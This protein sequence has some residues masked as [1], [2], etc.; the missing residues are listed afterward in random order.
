M[1]NL[2][3][4]PKGKQLNWQSRRSA[5]A[6]QS[7]AVSRLWSATTLAFTVGI[8]FSSL[9]AA[10]PQGGYLDWVVY[11][12]LPRSEQDRVSAQ[13]P[14]SFIDPWT[15]T[16]LADDDLRVSAGRQ[17]GYLDGELRVQDQVVIT[18]AVLRLYG[19]AATFDTESGL[20][21][22]PEGGLIRQ[23][24]MA[25]LT[26][27]A[28]AETETDRFQ[29]YDARY[30]LHMANL[31]GRADTIARDDFIYHFDRAWISRCTPGGF[32][33][34]LHARTLQVNT[35]TD[36]AT[37]YHGRLHIGPVP[38]AYTPYFRLNLNQ[39]RSSGFLAPYWTYHTDYQQ[40]RVSTP[41]YWAI[42]PNLDTTITPDWML[43]GMTKAPE[44][45]ADLDNPANEPPQTVHIWQE[46]RYLH[47]D[48]RG[49]LVVGTYPGWDDPNI[50]RASWAMDLS[51]GSRDT[52]WSWT[53]DYRDT[54]SDVY[55]SEFMGEEYAPVVTN[56]VTAGYQVQATQTRFD[57]RIEQQNIFQEA[58]LVG[59]LV[60]VE[61]P[62]FHLR[63]PINLPFNWRLQGLADWE[64]RYKEQ[65]EY[66][67]L[68]PTDYD[69]LEAYRLRNRSILSRADTF[70]RWTF[71]QQYTGDH[72]YYTMPTVEEHPREGY[73]R[74]LWDTRHRLSYRINLPQAQ[75]VTP[76]VQHEYRP[77]DE[78]QTKLPILNEAVDRL[79]DRNR[80]SV[81]SRYE[82]ADEDWRLTSDVAQ[83]VNL[84]KEL[85][86]NKEILEDDWTNPQA[87]P[88]SWNTRIISGDR[89]SVGALFVWRAERPT[90]EPDLS[91]YGDH[92]E[93][94]RSRLDYALTVGRGGINLSSDWNLEHATDNGNPFQ[95]LQFAAVAP[96]TQVFGVFG[97]ATLEKLNEDDELILEE[98]VVG[99][100]Y[101]GCCW[102]VQLAGQRV[103]NTLP[104][105]ADTLDES[106]DRPLFDTIQLNFS[107]KGLVDNVGGRNT[108][109][110]S[111]RERIPAFA[112]Q[113]FNTQ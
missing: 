85:L 97:S 33:W 58:A 75:T 9:G 56:R 28:A 65:P 69:P 2:S 43:G 54:N 16:G 59:D 5:R 6:Q 30:T 11:D 47:Q 94:R 4:K 14:G 105:E 53:L 40:Y 70:G 7:V 12:D 79:R 61:Q 37:G 44:D 110:Q 92:Y 111:V 81:G 82:V 98:T 26:T 103:L 91:F 18:Q 1:N 17:S 90:A 86:A 101:D 76:F 80:I 74:L 78:Q 49:E 19:E 41:F 106:P 50:D 8:G 24:D 57:A 34:S 35:D 32:G 77:L 23:P 27:Q 29:L 83:T 84:T 108:L 107:L 93:L 52:E 39:Q 102:H 3:H 87:G 71:T 22:L 42:A 46:W 45:P 15:D 13:C 38:V 55:Y 73:N 63:Q 112:G 72:T 36:F 96:I 48:F 113:L 21:T 104:T 31:H 89:H 64:R 109:V 67:E 100:E 66:L 25:I 68:L 10:Q 99:I 20:V 51:L 95:M 88:I 60:Y 62:G